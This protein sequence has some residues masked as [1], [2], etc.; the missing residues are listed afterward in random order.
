MPEIVAVAVPLK[1]IT[2]R[3]GQ[4]RRDPYASRHWRQFGVLSTCQGT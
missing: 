4:Y 3:G 1:M 2:P